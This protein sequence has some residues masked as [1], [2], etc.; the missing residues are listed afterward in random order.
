MLLGEW[1][2]GRIVTE[3]GI[4][5]AGLLA[6]DNGLHI[7]ELGATIPRDS[8][9]LLNNIR[10]MFVLRRMAGVSFHSS[11][12]GVLASSEEF[13]VKISSAEEV[14]ILREILCGGIY[15]FRSVSDK[16]VV[17]DI[18]MNVGM[19]SLYFAARP[20]V[21]AVIGCEPVPPT[22][23]AALANL[24]LNPSLQGKIKPYNFGVAARAYRTSMEY[25]GAW[26]ANVGLGGLPQG[27]RDQMRSSSDVTVE[28]VELHAAD[29]VL[30]SILAEYPDSAVVAKIDCEGSEYEIVRCLHENRLLQRLS[31]VILEWHQRGPSELEDMLRDA[32]FSTHCPLPPEGS[33]T[34]ML[35]AM[36][37][38]GSG[39]Q[40]RDSQSLLALNNA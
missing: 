33:P 11:P 18:G 9:W 17:W 14:Y 21:H 1:H 30:R 38:G 19:A 39:H 6:T 15:N 3:L 28:S 27:I 22:F 35:Y 8:E 4:S 40:T 37:Q 29:H 7:P 13:R 31:I 16:V 2:Y 34:G 23:Q 36:K 10:D 32:G 20:Y 12:D 25:N 24:A 5:P 26:K